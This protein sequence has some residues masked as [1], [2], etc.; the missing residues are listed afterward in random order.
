MTTFINRIFGEAEQN[1]SVPNYL[2]RMQ[3]YKFYSNQ[4]RI[5]PENFAFNDFSAMN[6]EP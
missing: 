4:M 5:I 6:H 3:N 2:F 1:S